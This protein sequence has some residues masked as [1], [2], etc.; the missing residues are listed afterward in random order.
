ML[1]SRKMYV[2]DKK[3]TFQTLKHTFNANNIIYFFVYDML[4]YLI[5]ISDISDTLKREVF[6]CFYHYKKESFFPR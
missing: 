5:N 2:L 3:I 1:K 4:K 6:F